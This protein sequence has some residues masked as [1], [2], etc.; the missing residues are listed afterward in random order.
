[1]NQIPLFPN[2]FLILSESKITKMKKLY[3]KKIT[4]IKKVEKHKFDQIFN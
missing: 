3:E 2:P 4:K 1:M